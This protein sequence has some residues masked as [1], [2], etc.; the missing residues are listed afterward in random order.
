MCC[1]HC[2]EDARFK[3]YRPKGIVSVL[4]PLRIERGYYHCPHCKQ[5]HCPADD[6]FGLDGGDLTSGATELVCLATVKGS[7]AKAAEID[8]PRRCGLHVAEST[9][10][11]FA[12]RV[13]AEA[14][15]AIQSKVPFDEARPWDWHRDAEGKTCA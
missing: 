7:F 2:S 1:P 3:G 12:E 6:A 8:L 4:G 15:Q 13:G 5:G 14:G 10:E 11:R 9:V